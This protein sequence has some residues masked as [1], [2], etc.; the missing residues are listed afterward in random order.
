L[1]PTSHGEFNILHFTT[2]L[3][4]H[5]DKHRQ[6]LLYLVIAQAGLDLHE[7][8]VHTVPLL[9]LR[10]PEAFQFNFPVLLS[11]DSVRSKYFIVDGRMQFPHRTIA[12]WFAIAFN[13]QRILLWTGI[14]AT[15]YWLIASRCLHQQVIVEFLPE[16]SELLEILSS[17]VH[18]PCS[19][20]YLSC[21]IL[22]VLLLVL[23]VF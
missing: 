10:Y 6:L 15:A 21:L 11:I 23:P 3:L 18:S 20:D 12:G 16:V 1:L 17:N 13:P 7:I 9:M 4:A 19:L 8:P 14:L 22:N 5:L 2:V